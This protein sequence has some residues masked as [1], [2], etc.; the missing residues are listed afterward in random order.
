MSIF[1]GMRRW[2]S[3]NL[4]DPKHPQIIRARTVASCNMQEAETGTQGQAG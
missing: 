1:T 4:L 2:V 3:K